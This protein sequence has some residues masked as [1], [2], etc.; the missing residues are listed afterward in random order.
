MSVHSGTRVSTVAQPEVTGILTVPGVSACSRPCPPA[1]LPRAAWS[2]GQNPAALPGGS[3]PGTRPDE[4]LLPPESRAQAAGLPACES[5]APTHLRCPQHPDSQMAPTHG[6]WR[7]HSSRPS[8]WSLRPPTCPQPSSRHR[9]PGGSQTLPVPRT[10]QAG[11]AAES[12]PVPQDAA[13]TATLPGWHSPR[14]QSSPHLQSCP[15]PR[16]LPGDHHQNQRLKFPP[17]PLG[18]YP[19]TEPPASSG[20]QTLGAASLPLPFQSRERGPRPVLRGGTLGLWRRRSFPHLLEP[21]F[22]GG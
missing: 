7:R 10:A 19:G 8:C 14:A 2:V 17:T 1:H 13:D 21:L 6:H 5:L 4:W 16:V 3:Q 15:G 12:V 22:S 20:L 11:C 9:G 18:S